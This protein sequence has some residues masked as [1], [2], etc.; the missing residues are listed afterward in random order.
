MTSS[1]EGAWPSI[2]WETLEWAPTGAR[3]NER[4][5]GGGRARRSYEAAVPPRVATLDPIRALDGDALALAVEAEGELGRLDAELGDR[6]AD[7]GPILL[8]S[9]SA[10]SSRIENLT[11]SARSILTAEL[12][13]KS[14]PNSIDIVAN[15]RAMTAALELADRLD[16]AAVLGMHRALMSGQKIHAAGEFRT[17][18]VWIGT[19]SESPIGADYVAPVSE[20]VPDLVDDVLEFAERLDV[21]AL[22]VAAIAH[23]QF[24]TIHPFTDGNG[25]TG[26]AFVQAILRHHGVTR[27]VVVPVSAGLLADVAGY[28]GALG[29]YRSGDPSPIVRALSRAALRACENA[30]SL[31]GE[32]V[33]VRADWEG[34]LSARRNSNAR[35]LLDVVVR[36]PVLD[37]RSAAADL[38]IAPTNVYAPL[39]ALVDAGVLEERNEYRFG[40]VW[41]SDEILAAL[42]RFAERAGRRERP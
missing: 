30:R 6:I 3:W 7:F 16:A 29:A 2:G 41:R 4:P 15:T 40:T 18:A 35:R 27:S 33:C 21:P 17:E 1:H 28:H 13:A 5:G 42:D 34:R 23:A 22:V 14:S 39:R 26:R 25:R 37:A 19:S 12:G 31:V 32:I 8:R 10:S 9:E 36:R 38:D 24:E 11:A 20:S